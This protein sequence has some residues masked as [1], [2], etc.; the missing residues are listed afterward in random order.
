M[1]HV[2]ILFLAM[3]PYGG[4]SPGTIR[5]NLMVCRPNSIRLQQTHVTPRVLVAYRH[6]AALIAN[7][8]QTLAR[9]RTGE[10][11]GP[12]SRDGHTRLNGMYDPDRLRTPRH[13]SRLSRVGHMNM[14]HA[15]QQN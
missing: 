9:N 2:R 14:Y 1:T 11:N 6:R 5:T 12:P 8:A 7:G 10:A 3:E 13:P 4:I 15:Y